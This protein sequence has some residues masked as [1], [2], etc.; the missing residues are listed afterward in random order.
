MLDIGNP[1]LDWCALGK[2]M[3]V[4]SV[5]VTDMEAFNRIF[6]AGSKSLAPLL[7]EVVM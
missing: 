1:T 6:L 5:R 7:I 3:G 4:E 2:A